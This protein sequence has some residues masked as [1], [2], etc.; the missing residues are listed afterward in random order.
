VEV[1][2]H[3]IRVAEEGQAGPVGGATG[4]MVH[5]TLLSYGTTVVARDGHQGITNGHATLLGGPRAGPA[6]GER[7]DVGTQGH[8]H[9]IQRSTV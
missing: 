7:S 8:H 3:Q 5:G 6:S 1:E 2:F 4:A 9:V